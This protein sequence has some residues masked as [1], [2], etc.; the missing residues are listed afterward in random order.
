MQTQTHEDTFKPDFGFTKATSKLLERVWTRREH[1]NV[2]VSVWETETRGLVYELE[3]AEGSEFYRSGQRLLKAIT[4]S[5]RIESFDAY[6]R[7][8][9]AKVSGEKLSVAEV[10]D[11]SQRKVVVPRVKGEL[12]ETKPVIDASETR[13]VAPKVETQRAANEFH[14]TSDGL[15]L[16]E[17][18][19][20][21]LVR[22][23]VASF[24]GLF[25][26][27][28]RPELGIDLATRGH[29]VRKLLFKGFRGLMFSRGYD[30]E[31]VLQEI[32]RGLLTRNEGRCPWDERKSTFGFYVTMVC[33][34]VLTNYHRKQSRRL[35]RQAV[36][37]DEAALDGQAIDPS[38]SS[39]R[40]AQESL[41]KWLS[42]PKRGGDTPDG[43]LAV[44]ILPLVGAGYQRR[45]I[46]EATGE[47]ETLV[48]R[49]L[50]H[51]RKWSREWA[52]EMGLTVRERR[53]VAPVH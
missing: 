38:D 12:R 53:R 46:I 41:E 2:P 37:L 15:K 52:A 44:E 11:E 29:E 35:D 49:A 51:L 19:D 20:E 7:A 14:V 13:I 27:I 47:R 10:L 25:E 30:P 6:F 45:E 23:L 5:R 34:C 28:A 26:E 18:A 22:Q 33:R 4:G 9:N 39:D 17:G 21:Q 42:D 36:E 32:Y 31:D 43:R 16:T 50:A 8:D 40:L 48:S 1:G 3:R 24:D